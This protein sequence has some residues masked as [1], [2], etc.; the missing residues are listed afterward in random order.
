MNRLAISIAFSTA[1][2]ALP[3]QAAVYKC[4][5]AAGKVTYSDTNCNAK[6]HDGGSDPGV[7]R[8]SARKTAREPENPIPPPAATVPKVEIKDIETGPG[9]DRKP[10]IWDKIKSW[11]ARAPEIKPNPPAAA[12]PAS[13]SYICQGKTRCTQ[14]HSCEEATFYLQNC[15]GVELDGDGDGIPCESQWCN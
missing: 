5:D 4:T 14:M 6:P 8:E 7:A 13:P 10:G 9:P 3:G 11:F 15:P 1:V 2:L 12:A